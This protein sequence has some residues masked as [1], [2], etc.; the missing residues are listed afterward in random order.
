[1][2]SRAPKYSDART[3]HLCSQREWASVSNTEARADA[4]ATNNFRSSGSGTW[5][6][7]ATKRPSGV[8]PVQM[9]VGQR[10]ALEQLREIEAASAGSVELLYT[11]EA[12]FNP[13]WVEVGCSLLCGNMEKAEGG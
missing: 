3:D 10:L 4:E 8:W 1:M 11:R 9:T 13:H 7:R 6:Q 2:H 5:E 12:G